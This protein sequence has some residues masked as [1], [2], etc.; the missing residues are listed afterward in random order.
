MFALLKAEKCEVKNIRREGRGKLT[1]R[2]R[3]VY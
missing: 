3:V 2:R 1:G